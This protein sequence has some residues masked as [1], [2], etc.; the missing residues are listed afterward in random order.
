MCWEDLLT[1]KQRDALNKKQK[2]EKEKEDR[3]KEREKKKEWSE[4]LKKRTSFIGR[5]V[6]FEEGRCRYRGT[7]EKI[8]SSKGLIEVFAKNLSRNGENYT[9]EGAL[10]GFNITVGNN[11]FSK[12]ENGDVR[13]FIMHIGTAYIHAKNHGRLLKRDIVKK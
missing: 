6:T 2:S 11:E 7:V 5:L 1:T 3:R 13:I 12:L 4:F 10:F 9:T 8:T